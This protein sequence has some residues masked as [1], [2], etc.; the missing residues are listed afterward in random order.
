MNLLIILFALVTLLT[1]IAGIY[2]MGRGGKLDDK[3]SNRLMQ[4]RVFLQAVTL[5]LLFIL[6]ANYGNN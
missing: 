6:M 1:L 4:L 5:I 3:Y 2:V